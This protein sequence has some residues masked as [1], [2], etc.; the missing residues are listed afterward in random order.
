M[1]SRVSALVIRLEPVRAGLS[2]RPSPSCGEC[3]K[4]GYDGNGHQHRIN[5]HHVLRIVPA[6][7]AAHGRRH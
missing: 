1:I 7:L 5:W 3:D 6:L 4:D 2:I